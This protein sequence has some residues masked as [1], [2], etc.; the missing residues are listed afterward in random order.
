MFLAETTEPANHNTLILVLGGIAALLTAAAPVLIAWI[1]KPKDAPVDEE[2]GKIDRMDK[3]WER[4]DALEKRH[5][6]DH[7]KLNGLLD[8]N[9]LLKKRLCDAETTIQE[10]KKRVC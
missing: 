6:E 9:L 5:I 8:E 10:L 7:T 1:K 3:M 2:A 4:I